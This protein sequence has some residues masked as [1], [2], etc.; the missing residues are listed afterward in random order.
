[1]SPESNLTM[2][3]IVFALVLTLATFSA[4]PI[5]DPSLRIQVQIFQASMLFMTIFAITLAV[6]VTAA[7]KNI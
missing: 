7:K 6:V 3:S 5:T 2:L 4:S 1:M